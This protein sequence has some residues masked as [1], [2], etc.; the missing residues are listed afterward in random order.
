MASEQARAQQR[1]FGCQLAHLLGIAIG[2]GMQGAHLEL[3]G[4]CRR[5]PTLIVPMQGMSSLNLEAAGSE[6]DEKA[7][8]QVGR[9]GPIKCFRGDLYSQV[10]GCPCSSKS[11]SFH[12]LDTYQ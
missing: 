10:E 9:L 2:E 4:E 5:Q 12:Q 6:E 1:H 8:K 7:N 3:S 11:S